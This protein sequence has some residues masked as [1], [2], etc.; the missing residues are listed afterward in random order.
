MKLL[1]S[2]DPEGEC[3][4]S[5][6][7]IV[8]MGGIGKT[9]L[10][11][12]VYNDERVQKEFDLKAWIY[13]SEQF[14]IFKITK[15]LVEEITSCSCSIEKLN[16]LQHDLKKRLLKKKFL[17]ILD[18][19]WNQNYISWETLKNPFVYGAPG[20]K[21]IVTT[22]IAHVASIM[23]TV[24][25]YYLSELCDDDCW[26]LF[27]K[28]V[29]FGYANSNVHQNLRKM[30]KQIIKKCKGLPLAVKTLAGLL[31]CKDDTREWY[32]V[33]NSEIWDLQNDESNILPALRLS[34][35]YLPSH[36]KRC[37]AY[38]SVF[39]KDYWR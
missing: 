18:D 21:I 13:V 37:F 7:P 25:P 22:R 36:V 5:V 38:C 35:H 26:M 16:L 39:P 11:Q 29:L 15:T 12:F 32:K 3:N 17:F 2:D 24:E 27:S 6:I 28:H 14:D 9:I 8:G 19:V 23:Q 4:I 31:R 20:S 30:G 1:F 33:L 34:Y 10:A